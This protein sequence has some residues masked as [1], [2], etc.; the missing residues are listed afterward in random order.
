LGEPS[1]APACKTIPPLAV[2]G[3]IDRVIPPFAKLFMAQR[4]GA[5]IVKVEARQF[6]ESSH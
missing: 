3:T 1:G 6:Y 5:H 4:S 2:V